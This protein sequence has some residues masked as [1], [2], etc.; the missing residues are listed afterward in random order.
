MWQWPKSIKFMVLHWPSS[1]IIIWDRRLFVAIQ[2]CAKMSPKNHRHICKCNSVEMEN[3]TYINQDNCQQFFISHALSWKDK[4]SKKSL[5]TKGLV[6][7]KRPIKCSFRKKKNV[8]KYLNFMISCLT[9]KTYSMG[10]RKK[11]TKKFKITWNWYGT[12][13]MTIFGLLMECSKTLKISLLG[14][15]KASFLLGFQSLSL[16]GCKSQIFLLRERV[17]I[18]QSSAFTDVIQKAFKK[19][20]VLRWPDKRENVY[21]TGY[22]IKNTPCSYTDAL[23]N[24]ECFDICE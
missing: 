19:K 5:G 4:M 24:K 18:C 9:I 22:I 14:I 16:R 21:S 2:Q 23:V 15:F 11:C 12:P 1:Y 8:S 13:L 7:R 20:E 17:L 10:P 6:Q 3:C